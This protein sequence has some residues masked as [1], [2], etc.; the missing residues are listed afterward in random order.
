M[1]A[2]AVRFRGWQRFLNLIISI[3]TKKT[4]LQEVWIQIQMD[5][6][7]FLLM[8]VQ[9][10]KPNHQHRHNDHLLTQIDKNFNTQ[11]QHPPNEA[12]KILIDLNGVHPSS[13]HSHRSARMNILTKSGSSLWRPNTYPLLCVI[14]YSEHPRGTQ[15][16]SVRK[17][18]RL[19]DLIRKPQRNPP[20]V[21]RN[22][23]NK[24]P[25]QTSIESTSGW[26]KLWGIQVY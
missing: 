17:L 18:L 12:P 21:Q 26:G 23:K 19:V 10:G 25:Q 24:C 15:N 6:H 4:L 7:H 2:D 3:Q 1:H 11:N 22:T 8:A 9:F 13:S 14:P 16:S 5:N 20:N